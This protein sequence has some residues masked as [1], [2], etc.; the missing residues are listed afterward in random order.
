MSK[1]FS[2]SKTVWLN[3]GYGVEF[4][5]SDPYVI[6][7]HVITEKDPTLVADNKVCIAS[8]SCVRN[9]DDEPLRDF[10]ERAYGAG[11]SLAEEAIVEH[12]E[13]LDLSTI[14]GKVLDAAK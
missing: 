4:I 5:I 12:R 3:N 9:G 14:L 2:V 6:T 13:S 1:G 8:D 10:A 11:I 7:L